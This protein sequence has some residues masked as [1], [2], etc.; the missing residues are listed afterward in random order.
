MYFGFR[1]L[2][3]L[4]QLTS[5][6]FY[7]LWY[8]GSVIVMA[9]GGGCRSVFSKNPKDSL[10]ACLV[11]VYSIDAVVECLCQ[12]R[13]K[14]EPVCKCECE[15]DE[16]AYKQCESTVDELQ[17]QVS[18]LNDSVTRLTHQVSHCSVIHQEVFFHQYIR[19]LLQQLSKLAAPVS[20][21]TTYYH[22]Y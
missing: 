20:V 4:S 21:H 17:S 14:D 8:S 22:C 9:S 13:I 6:D 10:L 16:A 18:S 11:I 3:L 19:S 1:C 2:L 5:V 15:Y 12:T 7:L